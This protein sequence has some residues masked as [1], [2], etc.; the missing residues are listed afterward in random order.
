MSKL[1]WTQASIDALTDEQKASLVKA[2]ILTIENTKAEEQL[3]EIALVLLD[4][5]FI[6]QLCGVKVSTLNTYMYDPYRSVK[7]KE[8]LFEIMGN[9]IHQRDI[10]IV[11]RIYK[12]FNKTSNEI[13]EKENAS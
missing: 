4:R 5:T 11:H 7:L 3:W 6:A 13:M 2:G 1:V 12:A 8:K 9:Q 10:A